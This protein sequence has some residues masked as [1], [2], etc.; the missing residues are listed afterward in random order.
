MKKRKPRIGPLDTAIRCRMELGRQYRRAVNDEITA[1]E[2]MAFTHC[3]RT[4]ADLVF[5][6]ELEV[7]LTAIEVHQPPPPQ[8]NNLR[9]I[10]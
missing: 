1:K 2:L 9:R 4:V 5:L 3:L 10:G 7:R 8:T 6:G